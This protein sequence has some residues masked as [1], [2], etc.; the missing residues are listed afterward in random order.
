MFRITDTIHFCR[1]VPILVVVVTIDQSDSVDSER[2]R[3]R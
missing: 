3:D 2:E 1:S